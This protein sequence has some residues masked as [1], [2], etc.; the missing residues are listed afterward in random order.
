MSWDATLYA[1]TDVTECHSCG[2]HLPEPKRERDEI[3]WWN[4]THNT[5]DMIA[6]AYEA[7]T[8]GKTEPCGGSLGGVI[9]PAW[10]YRLDGTSG[11]D[12]KA[13]LGQIIAGLEADPDRYRA[14]NPTNEWGSYGGLLELL[15]IMRDHV[16]DDQACEWSVSG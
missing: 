9:G 10:W 14:M 5:N 1:V 2:Q 6:A 12:G 13:Y 16:P 11:A 3:G 7:E 15:R 4:Y 8:G